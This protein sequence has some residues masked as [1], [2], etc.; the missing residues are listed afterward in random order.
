MNKMDW[1]YEIFLLVIVIIAIL[2]ICLS[3]KGA[4]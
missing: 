2:S 1:I 4:G 3:V